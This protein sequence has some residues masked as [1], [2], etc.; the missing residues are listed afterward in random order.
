MSVGHVLSYN[1]CMYE[2]RDAAKEIF[3]AAKHP[4]VVAKSGIGWLLIE[5]NTRS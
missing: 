1:K 2:G 4:V 5:T 3:V